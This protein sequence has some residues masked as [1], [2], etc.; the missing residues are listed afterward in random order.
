MNKFKFMTKEVLTKKL[1]KAENDFQKFLWDKTCHFN[2]HQ[3]RNLWGYNKTIKSIY[4][5]DGQRTAVSDQ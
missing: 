2:S 3:P 4:I 1:R 5:R